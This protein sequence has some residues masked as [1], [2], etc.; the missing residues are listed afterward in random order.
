MLAVLGKASSCRGCGTQSMGLEIQ[1]EP[2]VSGKLAAPRGGPGLILDLAANHCVTQR[3][4]HT[5][6]SR[7]AP[8][9]GRMGCTT[10]EITAV[11]T[12]AASVYYTL[13][14]LQAM[15]C[16]ATLLCITSSDHLPALCDRIWTIFAFYC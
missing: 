1:L 13:S 7:L 2:R 12:G 8:G 9:Q 11:M 10:T 14:V 6:S 3:S 4:P 15:P 5:D 16:S